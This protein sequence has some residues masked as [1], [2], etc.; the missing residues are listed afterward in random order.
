[1]SNGAHTLTDV[2]VSPSVI[3]M[4]APEASTTVTITVNAAD[5][6]QPGA[7]TGTITVSAGDEPDV[8][9][10]ASLSGL[11]IQT[12]ATLT[13]L[14]PLNVGQFGNASGTFTIN[15]IAG[16]DVGL[17]DI[18]MRVVSAL[19][20][21]AG[22]TIPVDYISFAPSDIE[23]IAYNGNATVTAG[24]DLSGYDVHAGTYTGTIHVSG[25]NFGA[26]TTGITVV[27]APSYDV[28]INDNAMDVA[29]N[30]MMLSDDDNDGMFKW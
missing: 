19:T 21:P 10:S 11:V 30:T 27:V 15:T 29:G 22:Y 20:G 4:L 25:E 17:C 8:T 2:M 16:N 28:D 7:Y 14:A 9:A 1:M 3:A 26:V 24:V 23:V 6:S 12:G 18:S 5:C 13:A